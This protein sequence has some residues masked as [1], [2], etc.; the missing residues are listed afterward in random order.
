MLPTDQGP[1]WTLAAVGARACAVA[2]AIWLTVAVT[3]AAIHQPLDAGV[4]AGVTGAMAAWACLLIV[5]HSRL[6]AA[7]L[8][9]QLRQLRDTTEQLTAPAAEPV[10]H[11]PAPAVSSAEELTGVVMPVVPRPYSRGPDSPIRRR[12]RHRRRQGDARSAAFAP[13]NGNASTAL[14]R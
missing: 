13:A 5:A 6:H 14:P 7:A 11:E 12:P 9:A 3:R 2:W 10:R 8:A 1:R 4:V